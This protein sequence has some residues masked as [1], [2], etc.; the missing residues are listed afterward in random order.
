MN[1]TNKVSIQA[2]SLEHQH[3]SGVKVA[4]HGWGYGD[5]HN[6][7]ILE[8]FKLDSGKAAAVCITPWDDG[9]HIDVFIEQTMFEAIGAVALSTAPNLMTWPGD[10][11]VCTAR[12]ELKSL[13]M[14][15]THYDWE[16]MESLDHAENDSTEILESLPVSKAEAAQEVKP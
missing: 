1:E 7:A 15:L 12:V 14:W 13:C 5:H 2:T 4:R 3:Y 9:E 16:A 10:R 11:A 6:D 8:L